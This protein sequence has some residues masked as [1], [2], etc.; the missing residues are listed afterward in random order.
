MLL[1]PGRYEPVKSC[2]TGTKALKGWVL[3]YN[4]EAP[5]NLWLASIGQ[6]IDENQDS[7]QQRCH[8]SISPGAFCGSQ[9]QHNRG[10]QQHQAIT[11][12]IQLSHQGPRYSSNRHGPAGSPWKGTA[13][14][15]PWHAFR[16]AS[17]MEFHQSHPSSFMRKPRKLQK[18]KAAQCCA[19][20]LASRGL[21]L[22][23]HGESARNLRSSGR[24]FRRHAPGGRRW[25]GPRSRLTS[26]SACHVAVVPCCTGTCIKTIGTSQLLRTH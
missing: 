15:D 13:L 7:R 19:V 5:L 4:E 2:G 1:F 24:F 25:M 11:S 6:G 18:S 17:L 8:Q 22:F 10:E 12:T 21:H 9:P 3:L 16:V 23:V 20:F 26:K 14:P